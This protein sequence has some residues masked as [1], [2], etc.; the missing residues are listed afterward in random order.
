M[1]KWHLYINLT[2]G[3]VDG[4]DV[5]IAFSNNTL[6]RSNGINNTVPVPTSP[7]VGHDGVVSLCKKVSSDCTSSK[8]KVHKVVVA[9]S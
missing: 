6:S 2:T 5:I 9:N 4:E 3:K 1:V 8:V 7:H